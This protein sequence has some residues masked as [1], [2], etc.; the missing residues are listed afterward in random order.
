M[1]INETAQLESLSIHK[2]RWFCMLLATLY[3]ELKKSC[4]RKEN[5]WQVSYGMQGYIGKY[6]NENIWQAIVFHRLMT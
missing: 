5:D 4:L 2:G 3:L 6:S 1:N